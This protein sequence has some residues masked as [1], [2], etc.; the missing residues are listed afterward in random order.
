M[1]QLKEVIHYYI[2]QRFLFDN[3]EWKIVAIN[4]KT[5]KG[6][7]YS[8]TGGD[9][10]QEIWHHECKPILRRLEDMTEEEKQESQKYNVVETINDVKVEWDTPLTFHYLLQQG[11]DLFGLI[12]SNQAI[13]SKTLKQ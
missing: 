9:R 2:G 6:W 8:A 12:D 4:R 10:Y 7:R 3:Q 13:G 5:V 11:F 1:I